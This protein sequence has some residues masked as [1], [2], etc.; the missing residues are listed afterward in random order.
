MKTDNLFNN[1]TE[2]VKAFCKKH[3]FDIVNTNFRGCVQE[4]GWIRDKLSFHSFPCSELWYRGRKILNLYKIGT[5]WTGVC[6][7]KCD[8]E[9]ER[10]HTHYDTFEE[11]SDDELI[12]TL[13]R[14]KEFLESLGSKKNTIKKLFQEVQL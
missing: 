1:G 6:P 4:E 2:L 11:L 8:F 10:Y 7:N 14:A 3:K 12:E 13:E 5:T 9:D